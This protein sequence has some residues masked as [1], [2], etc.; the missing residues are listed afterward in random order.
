MRITYKQMVLDAIIDLSNQEQFAT[1]TMLA[2]TMDLTLSIID[3]KLQSLAND[4]LIYR[5]QKG[6][7]APVIKHDVARGIW[8]RTLPC[9]SV[10]LDIGDD[11][12]LLL[13]PKEARTLGKEM[14][15][16]AMQYA[17]IEAG[18]HAAMTTGRIERELKA[19]RS[20]NRRLLAR[21]ESKPFELV[22]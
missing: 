10:K 16:D 11:I 22:G 15:G 5:V 4:G 6:V 9:G 21:L 3:E 13:T 2:E 12:V 20:E 1:R 17:N 18:H 7:Y 8:K 14:M 19:L